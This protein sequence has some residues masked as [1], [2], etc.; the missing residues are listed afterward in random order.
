MAVAPC[1]RVEGIELSSSGI[2]CLQHFATRRRVD[3]RAEGANT[4]SR[5]EDE[6]SVHPRQG[7]HEPRG[8]H[9]VE[10]RVCALGRRE[11]QSS[12]YWGVGGGAKGCL[13]ALEPGARGTDRVLNARAQLGIGLVRCVL[14]NV[15]TG[16]V[17]VREKNYRAAVS[18]RVETTEDTADGLDIRPLAETRSAGSLAQSIE[19]GPGRV[20][21][22]AG[23]WGDD[24]ASPERQCSPTPVFDDELAGLP[25]D[26]P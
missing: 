7:A 18:S 26:Q 25:A 17:V 24:A 12:P 13:E 22:D 6:R 20:A 10:V 11:V 14:P 1:S 21:K 16:E 9:P 15:E 4:E 5:I 3:R 19:D 8:I 23:A 2:R